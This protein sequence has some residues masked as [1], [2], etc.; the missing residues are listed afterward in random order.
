MSDI[1]TQN[2]AL[3]TPLRAAMYDF[4]EPGVR[5]A[6]EAVMAPDAICRFA[7]PLREMTGPDALYDTMPHGWEDNEKTVRDDWRFLD[8]P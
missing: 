4:S 3:I 6:L 5:A 2:K 7:H 1:H 8:S